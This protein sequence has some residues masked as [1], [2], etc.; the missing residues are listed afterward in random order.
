MVLSIFGLAAAGVTGCEVVADFAALSAGHSPSVEYIVRERHFA[1]VPC[2]R[3]KG[4]TTTA[5][6]GAL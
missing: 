2:C 4:S 5:I 1:V 6:N 3:R